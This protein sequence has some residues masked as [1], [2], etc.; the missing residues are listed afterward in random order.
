MTKGYVVPGAMFESTLAGAVMSLLLLTLKDAGADG[1]AKT[2]LTKLS[3]NKS[4]TRQCRVC[5]CSETFF[6]IKDFRSD[7]HD[8]DG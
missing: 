3:A 7:F 8:S 2:A 1:T 6:P 5:E 4:S